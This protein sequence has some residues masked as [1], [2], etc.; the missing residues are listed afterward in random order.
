MKKVLEDFLNEELIPFGRAGGGCINSG[1][2]YETKSFGKVFV[3]SNIKK[4]ADIMFRGEAA[5]LKAIVE[6]N[7]VRA[8]RP[9]D[10][11]NLGAHGWAL[12]TEYID[13]NG[14]GGRRALVDL[15]T[16]LAR[17]HKHNEESLGES[18]RAEG[19]V[20]IPNTDGR[21][22]AGVK[23]FG[24]HTETCCGFLPQ[25]NEWCDDWATFFVRNRLKVQVDMLVEKGNRDVLFVWPE[26][27]RK[28]TSLLTPCA[29]VVPALVHGDLWSGN[30]SSDGDGPVIFDPASAFC[31]P[32]YEQGI[33]DMFGGFGSDFWAA[34]HA[35][36]PQRPGRKQRVLLYHLFHSLNHWNHFGSSYRNSSLAMVSQI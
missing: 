4:G 35:V 22:K 24:F 18:K 9:I 17:M 6:T 10:V 14:E 5:S 33:M 2:G 12:I 32:E 23:Q 30:W 34:Y 7:T 19:Y 29:N 26:L 11:V 13:M 16:Q 31:D 1:R 21:S 8:P 20:G 27:E 36:L 15:G 28:A 25:K 3:K